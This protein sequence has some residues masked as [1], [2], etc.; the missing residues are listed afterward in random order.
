MFH[1]P[2]E[3]RKDCMCRH[4]ASCVEQPE[5]GFVRAGTSEVDF[6]CLR[7]SRINGGLRE[8]ARRA[9]V[10][11]MDFARAR[12]H[13]TVLQHRARG[14]PRRTLLVQARSNSTSP[15]SPN[16][17][18]C[19]TYYLCEP[20]R[21]N[22]VSGAQP[23]RETPSKSACFSKRASLREG[24]CSSP[25]AR[26]RYRPKTGVTMAMSSLCEQARVKSPSG[27]CARGA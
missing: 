3:H 14:R 2:G 20:A 21:T 17:W 5:M 18:H 12:S 16:T 22:S 23:V 10:P 8:Q 11:E 6:G 4:C 24:F 15:M 26:I 13:K 1:L 19:T 7:S 9:H 25:L 27:V